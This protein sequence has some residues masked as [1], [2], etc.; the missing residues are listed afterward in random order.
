MNENVL[1]KF[2]LT[3]DLKTAEELTTAGFE[4]ID[5]KDN[6]WTFLNNPSYPIVF[7]KENYSFSNKLC[8]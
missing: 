5:Y 7:S 2:I 3:Q 6:T 1:S 4:L 8:V